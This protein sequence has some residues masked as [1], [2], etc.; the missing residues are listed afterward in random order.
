MLSVVIYS[1]N[2][3]LYPSLR[4]S[5]IVVWYT[6]TGLLKSPCIAQQPDKIH[7]EQIYL[8]RIR[9]SPDHRSVRRK[10]VKI[11]LIYPQCPFSG[12]S[13]SVLCKKK[14]SSM[15]RHSLGLIC[16]NSYNDHNFVKIY[17]N[18]PKFRNVGKIGN[19]NFPVT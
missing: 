8:I 2:S 11:T 6:V 1:L 5:Q 17:Q 7:P 19:L 4:I 13:E 3:R 12:E 16:I 9:D 18:L 15:L 14:N 10:E